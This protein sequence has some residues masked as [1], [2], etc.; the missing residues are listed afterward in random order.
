M[1]NGNKLSV[2]AF[3]GSGRRLPTFTS[4][5]LE[6]TGTGPVLIRASVPP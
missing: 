2:I 5:F 4:S 6:V 1:R 3:L